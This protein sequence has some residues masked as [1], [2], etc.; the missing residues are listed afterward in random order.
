MRSPS[1]YSQDDPIS[2]ALKPPETETEA[3]RTARLYAEAEA[4]RVSEQIDEHLREER[5]RIRKRKGD[6]KV[7]P[8]PCPF[9]R[10]YLP[11]PPA[12]TSGTGRK[13]KI[14]TAKTVPTDVSPPFS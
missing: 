11:L 5:E 6:V 12:F 14:D 9:T 4:K 3:E 10:I 2:A 13:W 8:L 1:L 7:S